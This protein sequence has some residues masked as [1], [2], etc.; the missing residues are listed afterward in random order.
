MYK[1]YFWKD[2]MQYFFSFLIKNKKTI[3]NLQFRPLFIKL[4][5]LLKFNGSPMTLSPDKKTSK[6][7]SNRR[8]SNWIK[9][10]ARKLKDTTALN[11]QWNGLAHFIDED[12]KYD[13]KKVISVTKKK[14]GKK[15]TRI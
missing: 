8:T 13:W 5:L 11:K 1:V 4:R 14:K 10:S 12:G 7:R 3:I 2:F 6:S 9:L 15:T